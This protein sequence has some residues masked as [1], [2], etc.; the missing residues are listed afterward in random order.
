MVAINYNTLALF[1]T[2]SERNHEFVEKKEESNK[3]F[4]ARLAKV[5]KHLNALLATSLSDASEMWRNQERLGRKK[6]NKNNS[7]HL[8]ES[9]LKQ[10][11]AEK[12][13][14]NLKNRQKQK[15]LRNCTFIATGTKNGTIKALGNF[16]RS[17]NES[18]SKIHVF[19]SGIYPQKTRLEIF[20]HNAEVT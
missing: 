8:K 16:T 1:K 5:L 19:P 13:I 9:I 3:L 2:N 4:S 18:F 20:S 12:T 10:E 7:G 15:P 11:K 6:N 14:V 17:K